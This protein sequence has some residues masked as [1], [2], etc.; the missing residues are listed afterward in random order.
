M[1]YSGIRIGL[2]QPG[3]APIEH[4]PGSTQNQPQKILRIILYELDEIPILQWFVKS[5]QYQANPLN[6]MMLNPEKHQTGFRV[7]IFI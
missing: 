4:E 3:I 2:L 1:Q 5:R 6:Y 7:N